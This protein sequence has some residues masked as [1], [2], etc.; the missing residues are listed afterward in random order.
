MWF[1][2]FLDSKPG[3]IC[4]PG[5]TGS[6]LLSCL[7][8]FTLFTAALGDKPKQNITHWGALQDEGSVLREWKLFASDML[9]SMNSDLLKAPLDTVSTVWTLRGKS[10]LW[11]SVYYTANHDL[12]V[13]VKFIDMD[14]FQVWWRVHKHRQPVYY[15]KYILI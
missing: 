9:V 7:Y 6:V 2:H 14:L 12:K 3:V 15:L 13:Y 4:I 1:Q 8:S 11:W 5:C 10:G